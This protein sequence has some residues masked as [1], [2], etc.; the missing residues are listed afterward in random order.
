MHS[1][2]LNWLLAFYFA[3]LW[4]NVSSHYVKRADGKAE[5]ED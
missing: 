4:K 5:W 3:L 2:L 1:S